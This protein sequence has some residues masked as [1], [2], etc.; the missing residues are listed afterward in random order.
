MSD[1]NSIAP[2]IVFAV[3]MSTCATVASGASDSRW[4]VRSG[5]RLES[6]RVLRKKQPNENLQI[7]GLVV[8][9]STLE[10]VRKKFSAGQIHQEGDAGDSVYLLCYRGTD[11]ALVAF[12]SSGSMG[13]N[14]HIVT[15]ATIFRNGD[16][17]KFRDQCTS[18]T[19]VHQQMK[20]FK[21]S[22]GAKKT[23]IRRALGPPSKETDSLL[24]Y[25]Y[26]VEETLESGRADITSSLEVLVPRSTASQ[27]T[28]SKVVSY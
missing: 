6:V 1:P 12:E 20:A 3:W 18:S 23:T 25:A 24:L 7:L 19:E 22:L 2:A 27:I 21:I 15:S 26:H 11:S 28:A 14:D 10:D 5:A 9:S 13:G 16:G 8:G 4:E 17:Y